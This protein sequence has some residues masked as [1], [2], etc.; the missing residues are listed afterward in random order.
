MKWVYD[1][2]VGSKWWINEVVCHRKRYILVG[3]DK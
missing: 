1:G 3:L 2:N